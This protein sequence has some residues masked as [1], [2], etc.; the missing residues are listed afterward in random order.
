VLVAED[1]PSQERLWEMRRALS[2]ALTQK[3]P[4]REREDVVVPKARIPELFERLEGLSQKHKV[5]IVSFGHI[6][7]G[8]VHVN[9]LKKQT[10]DLAWKQALPQLLKELFQI[11]ISL[12]GTISGEHGIGYVKKKYLPLAVD[13]PALAV[14]KAVKKTIDPKNI[15]NPGKIFL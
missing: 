14:M 6:G 13:A 11:V 7:D 8:N 10:D 3:S 1:R 5:E 4:V 12:G 9:I 2:E 15:L